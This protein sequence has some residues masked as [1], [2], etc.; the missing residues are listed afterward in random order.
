MSHTIFLLVAVIVTCFLPE[1]CMPIADNTMVKGSMTQN[2]VN[3]GGLGADT[4]MKSVIELLTCF[5]PQSTFGFHVVRRSY[6][7]ME[8]VQHVY[9]SGGIIKARKYSFLNN[10]GELVKGAKITVETYS[11]YLQ[12]DKK[13][14]PIQ[15]HIPKFGYFDNQR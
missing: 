9:H 5:V 3:F 13:L 1:D 7:I 10:D 8:K 15:G 11:P 12:F 14:S 4:K 6:Y 2:D